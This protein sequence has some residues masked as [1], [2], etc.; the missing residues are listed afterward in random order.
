MR[1]FGSIFYSEVLGCI[2]K[3]IVIQEAYVRGI[4][5]KVVIRECM[6]RVADAARPL[7]RDDIVRADPSQTAGD[8]NL[9][10]CP[11]PATK[12]KSEND[13]K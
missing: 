5:G 9:P 4:A 13:H 1:L 2:Y 3:S 7:L 11:H 6:I 10:R 12:L 8:V